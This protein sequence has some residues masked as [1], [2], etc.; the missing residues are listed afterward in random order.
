MLTDYEKITGQKS[1]AKI[2][3]QNLGWSDQPMLFSVDKIASVFNLTF[4]AHEEM[5]RH[6][7]WQLRNALSKR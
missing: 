6:I 3:E 1:A 7:D 5:K 2:V 4:D